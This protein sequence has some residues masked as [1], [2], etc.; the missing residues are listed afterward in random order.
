MERRELLKMIAVLT[1]S[2]MIGGDVFLTGCKT[3]TKKGSGLLSASQIAVLDELGETILPATN[4]PGAK[5]VKIGEFMNVFV[6]DC[7]RPEQQ[8]TFTD[9]LANLD[10]LSKKQFNKKFLSLTP[11]QRNTLLMSLEPEAKEFNKQ[12]DEREKSARGEARLAMKE[13]TGAP[14]HYYTLMKQLTLFGYFTSEIGNKEALRF[15]PIPGKYDGAYPYKKGDKA[16][17]I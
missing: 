13:F 7:Y 9:G 3:A 10:D 8:K 12:L 14:P 15:L 2:A 6:T 1:G 5:A 4:T 16:W 11:E 17:A